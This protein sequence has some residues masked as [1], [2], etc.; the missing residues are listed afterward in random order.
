[1]SIEYKIGDSL[2]LMKDVPDGSIDMVLADPPY[3]ISK[4]NKFHTMGRSGIDFGE[5]DKGFDQFTWITATFRI[6][7]KGGSILI[8]NDWKNMGDIV[9]HAESIGYKTKDMIRWKKSNPM[10]RNRDRRY[11]TD[12][13]VA[14]WFVKPGAKWT[15]NR[16]SDTYDRCEYEYPLTSKCERVGHPTQKP[17]LLI[18][19][20]LQRHTNEGDL[21][22]DPFLG[23]G[24]T[25]IACNN[26]NRNFIGFEKEPKYESIIKKRIA[27]HIPSLQQWDNE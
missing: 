6:I 23:S 5:W 11:I 7:K 10:P 21:V 8:F 15:F 13:E 26:L 17:L 27:E 18:T 20:I 1:M 12:Y 3:N 2:E 24:T 4:R 25:L 22:L 9:K 14:V 19:E 16:L